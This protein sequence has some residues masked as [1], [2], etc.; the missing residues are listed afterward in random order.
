MFCIQC[1]LA[2]EMGGGKLADDHKQVLYVVSYLRGAVYDWIHLYF[3]D[4]LQNPPAKQKAT[5]QAIFKDYR[6]LFDAMEET[7]DYGDDTR[8]AERDIYQLR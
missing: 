4:F 7:F 6:T 3:K 8:E 1:M 2:I 5:T